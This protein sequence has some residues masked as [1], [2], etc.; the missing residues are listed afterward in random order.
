MVPPL[1][2]PRVAR[3]PG[4]DS[5]MH[6]RQHQNKIAIL[7]II[8][9]IAIAFVIDYYYLVVAKKRNKPL[10]SNVKGSL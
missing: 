8:K 6:L 9:G 3:V 2:M 1:T 4:G 10:S 7:L 5:R